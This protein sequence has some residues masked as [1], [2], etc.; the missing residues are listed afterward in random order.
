[1]KLRIAKKIIKAV[2]TKDEHRYSGF[3]LTKA[4]ERLAKTHS[5]KQNNKF[6]EALCNTLT[7]DQRIKALLALDGEAEAF[8]LM[9]ET[10]FLAKINYSL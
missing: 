8:K 1:M 2:N 10:P 4:L 7:I 3:Q 5:Y 9:M 6:F